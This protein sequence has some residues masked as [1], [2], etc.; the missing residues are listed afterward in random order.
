[1]RK[2]NIFKKIFKIHKILGLV[3]AMNFLILALTGTILIWKEEL[4]QKVHYSEEGP[5]LKQDFLVAYE[6]LKTQFPNKKILSLAKDD[7]NSKIINIRITDQ[8]KTKFS[9]ATKLVYNKENQSIETIQNIKKSSDTFIDFILKL[10]RDILLGGKGKYLIGLIGL[11]LIFILLSG[12]L[13]LKKFKN[14]KPVSN[15]RTL[16]GSIHNT[17]G[18]FTFS[19]LLIVSLTGVF[20]SFNGLIINLYFKSQINAQIISAEAK[21]EFPKALNKAFANLEGN[22][23]DFISFPDN[24]FSTPSSYSILLEEGEIKRLMFVSVN[25]AIDVKVVELPFILKTI[26]ISEPLHYG[27][28][29]GATLKVIWTIFSLLSSILPLSALLIYLI[30]KKKIRN[31]KIKKLNTFYKTRKFQILFPALLITLIY[32]TAGS[33][34]TTLL[35]TLGIF[36]ILSIL[37]HIS[38]YRIS[39]AT[40]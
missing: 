19:W 10:H 12:I 15:L 2:S 29:G 7:N 40:E 22:E 23:V 20:L 24:E 17:I 38:S 9:G 11:G 14:N 8:G 3:L 21:S 16:V 32:L 5:L 35:F 27:N 36:T 4:T 18:V 28:F 1:M 31:L 30:R 37:S 13:I 33:L 39:N 6:L 25:E 26:I 34:Q